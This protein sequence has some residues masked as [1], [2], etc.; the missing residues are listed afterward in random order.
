[1]FGWMDM[2]P[3]IQITG[4]ITHN[5]E[6]S[7][8]AIEAG[9]DLSYFETPLGRAMWQAIA[10]AHADGREPNFATV[11]ML[12]PKELR[13]EFGEASINFPM[14]SNFE[15]HL[16][17]FINH[18]ATSVGRKIAKTGPEDPVEN[19]KAIHAAMEKIQSGLKPQATIRD[20]AEQW[21]NQ[22]EAFLLGKQTGIQTHIKKL[23][24]FMP[25]GFAP[26]ALY[27]LAARP[28]IG[29]TTLA[30]SF[31]S[32]VSKLNRTTFATIEMPAA[33]IFDRLVANRSSV[34]YALKEPTHQ[35]TDCIMQ[36]ARVLASATPLDIWDDWQGRWDKL[37]AKLGR[38][39]NEKKPPKLIIIDHL[40]IMKFDSRTRESIQNLSEIT[41]A[42]KLFAVANKVA[43]LL[44]SQMNRTIEQDGGRMPR[45]SDLRGSGSI[46]QDADV[47]FFLHQDPKTEAM[48]L[49][50]AKNRHGQ[51][52]KLIN[53]KVNYSISEMKGDE[54]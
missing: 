50:I 35:Q 15:Y 40:A 12:I 22:K 9:V 31:A 34:P 45:L 20:V 37:E 26:G 5:P 6:A 4:F 11:G 49:L 39:M 29:K 52:H 28:G 38:A 53:L 44:C 32:E 7:H 3:E 25:R 16:E 14:E 42:V 27:V 10:K 19:A 30:I 24:E 33:E 17:E 21:T 18:A 46:E 54:F 36:S 43:I 23:N 48:Q 41:G 13:G 8:R 1:M 47:V 51:A 2:H